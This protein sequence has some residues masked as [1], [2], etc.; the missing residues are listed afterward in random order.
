MNVRI[1]GG[2]TLIELLVVI[3]II[4]ILIALLLP[5]VQSA[6][7]AA[8]QMQCTNNL[9][10]L[11]MAMHVYHEARESFPLG[12]GLSRGEPQGNLGW[13]VWILPQLEESGAYE[14]LNPGPGGGQGSL[15]PSKRWIPGYICPSAPKPIND[16]SGSSVYKGTNYTGVTGAGLTSRR[17]LEDSHCGD[18]STD[19][20]LFPNSGVRAADIKDGASNT[21]AIGE[22][23][24]QMRPWSSGN[25][26]VGTLP[27]VTKICSHSTKNVR[28]PLNADPAEIGYYVADGSAPGPRTMLFN[29]FP[30]DSKH[31]SGANFAF[32]DG[33]VHFVNESIGFSIYQRLA[34]IADGEVNPWKP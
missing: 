26:W 6:R 20:M 28:W 31:T 23:T 34:M 27:A 32:A 16:W 33:S 29:D 18:C 19:G 22:R 1:R 13:H 11:M 8:R 17:N 10:Q 9:R 4:G 2:F 14:T 5:A 25:W 12:S 3:A 24:Y 30:F 7:E 15:E 21:L